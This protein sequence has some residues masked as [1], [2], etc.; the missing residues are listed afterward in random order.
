MTTS[1]IQDRLKELVTASLLL[2]GRPILLEDKGNLVSQ[3]ETALQTQSLAVTIAL[4]GGSNKARAQKRAAWDETFEVVIHRGLLDGVDVPATNDVLDD[5]R[6]RLEGS[7]VNPAA[8]V[9]EQFTCTRHDLREGGDGTYA[10]VL[11]VTVVN[12]L[13]EHDPA[14]PL[15]GFNSRFSNRFQP[16]GAEQPVH[17]FSERFSD[18]FQ[19]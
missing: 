17:G 11:L 1:Q 10:R 7:P 18:R 4:S 2:E 16:G 19:Q 6:M 14:A 13:A 8:R 9:C 12:T 15:R 3:I 5:L